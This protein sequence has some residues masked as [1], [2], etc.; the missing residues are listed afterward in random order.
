L[1][2]KNKEE[3]EIFMATRE[4]PQQELHLTNMAMAS[5]R[6]AS[7]K[8][9]TFSVKAS[10]VTAAKMLDFV[11]EMSLGSEEFTQRQ[12][13]YWIFVLQ[14]YPPALIERA[15]HEWVKQSKHMPVPSEIIAMLD[16]MVEADRQKAIH[17]ETKR[18]IADMQETRRQLAVVGLPQGEQQYH[19]LMKEALEVARQFPPF[20]DPNRPP[21]FTMRLARIRQNGVTLRK[22]AANVAVTPRTGKQA[23]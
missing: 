16:A 12:S 6:S 21:A 17:T 10:A 1:N 5:G 11:R 22:P 15:F 20:P 14:T 13:D 23:G 18:Y 4:K 3:I 9:V 19:Q 7:N 2:F 8:L